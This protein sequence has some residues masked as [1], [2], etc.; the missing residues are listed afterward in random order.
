MPLA[1]LMDNFKYDECTQYS[2]AFIGI[3]LK[4]MLSSETT[5]D[6]ISYFYPIS[7]NVR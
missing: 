3:C 5:V 4:I 7:I 6:I 2:V 1:S